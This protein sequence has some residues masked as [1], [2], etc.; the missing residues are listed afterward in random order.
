MP[1]LR[2]EYT[3]NIEPALRIAELCEH[4]RAALVGTLDDEGKPVFP[5][6]GTRVLAFPAQHFA[7]AGG[8]ENHAFVWLQMRINAG[9]SAVLKKKVG[10]TL[11]AAV[12]A[13]FA[14][15]AAT[16]PLG[17]RLQIDEGTEIYD[18]KLNNLADHL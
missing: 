9:R 8:N 16:R 17:L 12:D 1:H 4:L 2:I 6:S 18:G 10:D 3:A 5:V 15:I 7:V 14:P 13:W 11:M